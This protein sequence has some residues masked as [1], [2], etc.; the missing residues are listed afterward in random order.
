MSVTQVRAELNK[1]ALGTQEGNRRDTSQ[2][3]AHSHA[4]ILLGCFSGIK[5][6]HFTRSSRENLI[7]ECHLVQK[8]ARNFS[9]HFCL[10]RI[11][12]IA[13]D[14]HPVSCVKCPSVVPLLSL[15]RSLVPDLVTHHH[16]SPW[17]ENTVLHFSFGGF[18]ISF[19]FSGLMQSVGRSPV[20]QYQSQSMTHCV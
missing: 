11:S 9:V 8:C 13:S 3:P 20:V 18:L 2:S 12:I 5:S 14:P 6:R 19:L 17:M 15:C 10:S 1:P 4:F 16:Q 7:K